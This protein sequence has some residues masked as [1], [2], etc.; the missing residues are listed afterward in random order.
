MWFGVAEYLFRDPARL[1]AALTAAIHDKRH[2][3]DDVEFLTAARGWSQCVRFGS[4]EW[5][6]HRFEETSAF[7]APR[8][9]ESRK[10]AAAM[11]VVARVRSFAS[12]HELI[13]RRLTE[14]LRDSKT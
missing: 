3:S 10:Q 14:I 11:C 2:R 9:E 6:R 4:F 12:G 13:A 8:F 7:F 5:Y 1:D